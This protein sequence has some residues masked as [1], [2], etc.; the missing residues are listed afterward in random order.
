MAQTCARCR[1]RCMERAEEDDDARSK[2]TL[3]D[4]AAAEPSSAACQRALAEGPPLPRPL[5]RLLDARGHAYRITTARERGPTTHGVIENGWRLM[6]AMSRLYRANDAMMVKAGHALIAIY[7]ARSA[8]KNEHHISPRR[9][10]SLGQYFRRCHNGPH[11]AFRHSL[12]EKIKMVSRR[13][14][15][16]GSF[17]HAAEAIPQI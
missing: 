9:P 5:A 13:H 8:W 2:M 14:E 12:H 3:G 1:R 4:D 17:R 7:M 11:D 10:A 6:I 16:A 15:H